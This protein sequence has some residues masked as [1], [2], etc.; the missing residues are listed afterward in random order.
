MHF[1]DAYSGIDH[2]A[3]PRDDLAK[4]GESAV[5]S[6]KITSRQLDLIK[7]A[8]AAHSNRVENYSVFAAAT[9]LAVAAG[10]PS[11]LVNTQCLLY[12]VSSV[13]YGICYVLIDTTPLSLLRTVCW[14]SGCWACF[15]M[16]WAAGKALNSA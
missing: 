6:G 12:S 10:V 5:K 15:R 2:N 4:F 13:A 9:V 14:Y 16:F 1:A 8:G 7:R 3:A 11:D